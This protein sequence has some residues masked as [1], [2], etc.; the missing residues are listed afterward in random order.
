MS[1]SKFL[2]DPLADEH[3]V[4]NLKI[5]GPRMVMR[6]TL[7]QAERYESVIEIHTYKSRIFF[8]KF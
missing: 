5:L 3:Y 1:E 6:D 8:I 2:K 4:T 7:T